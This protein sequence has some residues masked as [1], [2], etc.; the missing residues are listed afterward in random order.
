MALSW[1]LSRIDVSAFFL[2]RNAATSDCPYCAAMSK[3]VQP[4]PSTQ[5][6]LTPLS[7]RKRTTS[8]RPSV[9]AQ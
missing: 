2:M 6:M 3:G 4:L 9:Q 8:R 1:F 5:L 7:T